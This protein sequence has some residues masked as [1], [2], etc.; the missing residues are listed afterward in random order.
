MRKQAPL[1]TFDKY[2]DMSA[3]ALGAI[4]TRGSPLLFPFLHWLTLLQACEH[5][6]FTDFL[7][8]FKD[9][10][11]IESILEQY[12]NNYRSNQSVKRK[13]AAEKEAIPD[14]EPNDNTWDN[15]EYENLEDANANS[16]NEGECESKEVSN[17]DSDNEGALAR[18][19]QLNK[20]GHQVVGKTLFTTLIVHLLM[21]IRSL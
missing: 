14:D 16:D 15:S 19:I 12:Y 5:P 10:W 2:S 9:G 11:P 17:A 21:H 7:K 8:P 3:V 18:R 1:D 20:R 13:Q 4:V 6:D